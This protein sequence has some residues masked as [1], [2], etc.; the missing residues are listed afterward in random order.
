MSRPKNPENQLSPQ[1]LLRAYSMGIFPMAESKDDPTVFWVDPE[2]RG[3][4]PL[5]KFHVSKS[6]KK[7][8]RSGK[9][10]IT[11]DTAFER[12]MRCC[13]TES[14][15][16][17][18]TWI[19]DDIVHAYTELHEFGFAH[20]VETWLDGELVGGLYGVSMGAAFFGESMFSRARDAS[21]VALVHLVAQLHQGGY[22]LLDT[23]FVTDHL[24]QFGAIEIP[25]RY[26]LERLES[27]LN[28][29]AEFAIE[30]PQTIV[31]ENL[32]KVFALSSLA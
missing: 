29:K 4:I 17:D 28:L 10:R 1:L 5:D 13:A 15:T 12:V 9:F 26:Y 31:D 3:I 30:L 7:T 27:A 24:K 16:R 6:L 22:E 2:I 25:A 19:N 11:Y 20:S 32:E 18:E 23:Q 8:I 14:D 21:K